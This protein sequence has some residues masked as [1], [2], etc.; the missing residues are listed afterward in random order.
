MKLPPNN[1]SPELARKLREKYL[2]PKPTSKPPPR[3]PRVVKGGVKRKGQSD[4][5]Q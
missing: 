1:I 4:S 5:G 3:T 2:V